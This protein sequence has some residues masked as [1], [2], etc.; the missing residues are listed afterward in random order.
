MKKRPGMKSLKGSRLIL[1]VTGSIA[2]YKAVGLAR[3]LTVAGA[4]VTTVMTEAAGRFVTPLSFQTVTRSPVITGL[5]DAV[6]SYDAE[7]VSLAKKADLVVV[8][9]ATANIIGKAANGIADDVASCLLMT[10]KCPVIY[11]P[12]MNSGMF[13]APSVQR[14]IETLAA[15]GATFV[16]P[17]EGRLADGSTGVGRLAD[18]DEIVMVV[19]RVL[20]GL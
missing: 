12:A 11:A 18:Q 4:A 20:E 3:E 15:W 13:L 17:S 14:N 5:W 19:K 6:D 7:H 8:A 9:P 2:A 1:C 16:G 10:V